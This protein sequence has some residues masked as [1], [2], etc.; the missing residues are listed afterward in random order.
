VK[1]KR[2]EYSIFTYL[3]LRTLYSTEEFLQFENGTT[4]I[5]NLAFTLFSET[6]KL[7]MPPHQVMRNFEIQV[8][9]VLSRQQSAAAE[10]ETLAALRDALLPKLISGELRVKDA[11]RFLKER[12]L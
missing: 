5:K 12:G 6:Y 4:G 9:P 11:E 7:C 3:W 10:S 1:L 8:E 2:H